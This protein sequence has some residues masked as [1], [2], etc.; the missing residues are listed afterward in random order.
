MYLFFSL[1]E[2]YGGFMDHLDE[3]CQDM[4]RRVTHGEQALGNCER[5]YNGG[6]GRGLFTSHI[7]FAVL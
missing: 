1:N 6:G 7:S 3:I 2:K 5:G 4:V